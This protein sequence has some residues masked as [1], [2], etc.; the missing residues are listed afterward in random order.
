MLSGD[1]EKTIK[2]SLHQ[3]FDFLKELE[4][5]KDTILVLD[6][7][8]QTFTGFDQTQ[9]KLFELKT[10]LLF[11]INDEHQ[12]ISNYLQSATQKP[13]NYLIVIIQAGACALG[14]FEENEMMNHKV[15]RK[16]MTRAKQGKAQ[17]NYL[18]TKGK[19]KAGSR[20][21]LAQT[22]DFF[23]E[24]NGKIME[25]E[26]IDETSQIFYSA[27][28][29]LWNLMFESKVKCPFEKKDNRLRK[30]PKDIQAPDFEELLLTNQFVSNA[31]LSVYQEN[32]FLDMP[33][34]DL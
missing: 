13:L 24:I 16:Y 34:L 14:Y 6:S 21:R 12:N 27:S 17:Y 4:Q 32:L 2:I 19:S 15:I 26:I 5:K 18:K 30:I 9:D 3:T 29:P 31:L 25:W 20:V 8:K 11:P 33:M 10:S 28:I 22:I 7:I 23:E 1:F